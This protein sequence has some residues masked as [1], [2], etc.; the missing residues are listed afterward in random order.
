MTIYIGMSSPATVLRIK[1][2]DVLYVPRVRQWF[3]ILRPPPRGHHGCI[4]G[5]SL[6]SPERDPPNRGRVCWHPPERTP[7]GAQ[8]HPPRALYYARTADDNTR[9]H[10][11]TL[12]F[13]CRLPSS[14]VNEVDIFTLELVLHGFIICLDTKGAHGDLWGEDGLGLVH[15]EERRLCSFPT[16]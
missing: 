7:A 8:D 12:H 11:G 2:T 13:Y 14:L 16:G 6:G 3:S 1:L 9:A 10:G 5:G 15:Q 4:Q